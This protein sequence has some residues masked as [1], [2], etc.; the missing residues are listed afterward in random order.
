[1][2]YDLVKNFVTVARTGNITRTAEILFVSQSTVSHRLQLLEAETGH[3]LVD[4]GKGK[5]VATLTQWGTAFLPIAEKWLELWQETEAFRQEE[6]EQTLSVSC[7]NSL[8]VC[9]LRRFFSDFVHRH[10]DIH[11]R[12]TVLDTDTIYQKLEAGE[13]GQ[14]LQGCGEHRHSSAGKNRLL[15]FGIDM[16]PLHQQGHRLAACR[17]GPLNDL[18]TFGNE[19][20]LFRLKAVIQLCLRQPGIDIQPLIGKIRNNRILN[21]NWAPWHP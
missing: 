5:R 19:H 2:T 14:H 6:T 20:G 12:L 11:L 16:P 15:R 3:P 13:L 17:K 21:H 18:G 10:P 9:L 4:R 7:V 8:T 1:M